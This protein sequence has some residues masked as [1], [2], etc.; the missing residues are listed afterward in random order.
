MS[1]EIF[2]YLIEEQ[3]TKYNIKGTALGTA[4]FDNKMEC[5]LCVCGSLASS[6]V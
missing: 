6:K 4:Y 3:F 2:L 1:Y 5:S